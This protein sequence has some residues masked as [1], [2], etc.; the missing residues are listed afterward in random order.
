VQG[1]EEVD[2]N[3]GHDRQPRKRARYIV[4]DELMESEDIETNAEDR[5]PRKR[6]WRFK[7]GKQIGGDANRLEGRR[8]RKK[9]WRIMNDRQKEI[10]EEALRTDPDM[11]K[12]R[13]ALQSWTEELKK[14]VNCS[15][16]C[17]CE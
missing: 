3:T 15:T 16:L 17:Q 7:N 13:D 2:A 12:N 10:M 8:A 4:S 1:S 14:Y 6:I 11:Q 5:N 9:P